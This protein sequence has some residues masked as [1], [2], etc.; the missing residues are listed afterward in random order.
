MQPHPTIQRR[1]ALMRQN[2]LLADAQRTRD[3]AAARACRQ[4]SPG[5]YRLL[6]VV[7][8]WRARPR[9]NDGRIAPTPRPIV[10]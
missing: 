10:R 5:I 4:H 2:D 3:I 7:L 1:L 9:G 6:R 8:C